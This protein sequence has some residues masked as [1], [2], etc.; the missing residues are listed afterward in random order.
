MAKHGE[1]KRMKSGKTCVILLG[2]DITVTDRLS[3]QCRD[4][5][6]LAADSGIRHAL[7]LGLSV[8][9]WLGDFDSTSE[10]LTQ[11][12]SDVPKKAFPRDKDK[13]DGELAVDEAIDRGGTRL[14][15]AGAF[16]GARTD[17]VFLHG[18][19]A[20]ALARRGLDVVL[21]NGSEEAWPVLPGARRFD[22]EPGMVFSLIGF[23][24]LEGV[25]ITGAKWPLVDRQVALG[26]SLTLSNVAEGPVKLSIRAGEG[27]FIAGSA[28]R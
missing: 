3:G 18:L 2:G 24:P 1:S 26:S 20:V 23:S 25:S 14:V 19:M 21:T 4:A 8:D 9:C 15:L 13:T 5:L 22:L 17:H 7:A 10:A 11:A 27:L 28:G 6:V 16:G 12:F